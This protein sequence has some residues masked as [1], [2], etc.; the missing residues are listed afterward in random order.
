VLIPS[1]HFRATELAKV[2]QSLPY[3]GFDAAFDRA[4]I[5]LKESASGGAISLASL[6]NKRAVL[7]W[8]PALADL[9]L[10]EGVNK[11]A[12]ALKGTE[13]FAFRVEVNR[14]TGAIERASAT[15]DD[16]DMKVVGAPDT[17]PH[18]K[19]TRTVKIEPR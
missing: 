13:H 11:S 12:A 9:Q 6:D 2:G 1:A 7:D 10:V 16:L 17:V 4:G 8:A 19:I 15:Y 18:L 5:D 3:G 14:K